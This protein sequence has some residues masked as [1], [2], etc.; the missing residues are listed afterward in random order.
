MLLGGCGGNCGVKSSGGGGRTVCK[1]GGGRG[2]SEGE[3]ANLVLRL[4]GE[5]GG[6]IWIF[7]LGDKG[8]PILET[9]VC[10]EP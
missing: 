6:G 2:G 3:R 7:R 9:F 8:G 10:D 5:G 4:L 1:A